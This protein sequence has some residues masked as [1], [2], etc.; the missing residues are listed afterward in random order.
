M[1]QGASDS[2]LARVIEA[3]IWKKEEGHHIGEAGFIKPE[4][5]MSQIGG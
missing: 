4:K 1:R 3:A 2:S 5:S